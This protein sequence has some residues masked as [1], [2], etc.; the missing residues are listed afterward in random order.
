MYLV[1]VLEGGRQLGHLDSGRPSAPA[2]GRPGASADGRSC[3]RVTVFELSPDGVGKCV[4]NL[5]NKSPEAHQPYV[6]RALP[7]E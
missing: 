3:E 5:S 6:G 7:Q 2:L 4:E 1:E